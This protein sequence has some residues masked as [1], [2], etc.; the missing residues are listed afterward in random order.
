MVKGLSIGARK[1]VM[2]SK[3]RKGFSTRIPRNHELGGSTYA[4]SLNSL[5]KSETS[6]HD[7]AKTHKAV[8]ARKGLSGGTGP[9]SRVSGV[10]NKPTAALGFKSTK[11]RDNPGPLKTLLRVAV[12]THHGELPFSVL[13]AEV[14][15]V[16]SSEFIKEGRLRISCSGAEVWLWPFLL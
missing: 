10:H 16:C 11:G 8:V 12:G 6:A 5:K 9:D 3:P 2:V 13:Q 4:L 7:R 15:N 1:K 14:E